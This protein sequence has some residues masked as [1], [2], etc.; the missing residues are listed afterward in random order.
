MTTV[1]QDQGAEI[2]GI[3]FAVFAKFGVGNAVT[4]ATLVRTESLDA[5]QCIPK[6]SEM[7]G[8]L[9]ADP[10]GESFRHGAAQDGG[11]PDIDALAVGEQYGLEPDHIATAAVARTY[12]SRQ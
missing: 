4:A 1:R 9:V 7:I 6:R 2:D 11:R 5:A 8:S 3:A 12:E 10:G